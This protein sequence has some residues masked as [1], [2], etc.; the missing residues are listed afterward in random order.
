MIIESFDQ[1]RMKIEDMKTQYIRYRIGRLKHQYWLWNRKHQDQVYVDEYDYRVLQNCKPGKTVFFSCSGYYLKDIW[2]TDIDIIETHPIV[3]HF[4]KDAYICRDRSKLSEVYPHKCDNFAVVNNRGDH[5]VTVDGLTDHL[6]N[7]TKIMNPGCR[8]FY[9]FRD[10][11]LHINRL[12]ID[13][14]QYFLD[15]A[16]SLEEKL[17]LTLMWHEIRF[18]KKTNK[19]DYSENPDTSNGNIKFMFVYK[20]IGET[21]EII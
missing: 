17:N 14:E 11:Q 21:W 4:Y 3:K 20:D 18:D 13:M 9:S 10:T 19:D 16:K 5:W 8:V 15:W 2:D 6:R 7:Y 1:A 12:K